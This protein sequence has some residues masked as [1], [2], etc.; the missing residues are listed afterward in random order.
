MLPVLILYFLGL[1]FADSDPISSLVVSPLDYET[2][3]ETI[4]LQKLRYAATDCI[5]FLDKYMTKTNA[6]AVTNST[7]TEDGQL[8]FGDDYFLT[9]NDESGIVSFDT[10][11][12][13]INGQ[14]SII[15]GYLY[16]NYYHT[17]VA[18]KQAMGN[19]SL[20]W[21]GASS[22]AVCDDDW[23]VVYIKAYDSS[24]EYDEF[25]PDGW[26]EDTASTVVE[27]SASTSLAVGSTLGASSVARN[28]GLKASF[29]T[30]G[31]A[32]LLGFLI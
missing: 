27:N 24:G 28:G 25:K 5:F 15:D 4:V 3:N 8:T 13:T 2:Y 16:Y 12:T 6:T 18:C 31:L 23:L 9:I 32:I 26:Y 19:Y 11:D 10:D 21:R 20:I 14:F 30:A 1:C 17:F 29:G 22:A 7:I